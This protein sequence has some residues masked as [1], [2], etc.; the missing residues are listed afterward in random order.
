MDI[1]YTAEERAFRDEVRTFLNEKLPKDIS[2]KVKEHKRLGKEDT[3]RWQKILNE[4][5]WLALHWPKEYGGAGLT[6]LHEVVWTQEVANYRTRDGYFVIGIGNCGPAIMHF[7]DEDA[8]RELLPRM[9]SAEDVWCQLFSEP[10]AGSDVAGLRTRAERDGDNWIVNGQKIWTS[11]AQYSD[12]GVVLTRTDPDV[13]KYAGLTMFMIDMRQEGVEVR[14]IKQADGGQH[15]NEVFFNDAVIPDNYRLGE[16]GGGWSGA[17]AVLMSERL[18]IS[19]IQPTGF[20]QFLGMVRSLQLDGEPVAQDPLVRERLA[21]WYS[22]Y[23]GLQ[24]AN[25]RMITAV[26][27]GGRARAQR[28]AAGVAA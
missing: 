11:G 25:K 22:Q 4:Q 28:Q 20:P 6:A 18:A 9:A 24:A 19:G 15:F 2:S 13:S 21:T 27:K 1:N 16:V 10:S 23:A 8:R 12:Y 7:A 26:A 3:I 5:G 17:L 14:P